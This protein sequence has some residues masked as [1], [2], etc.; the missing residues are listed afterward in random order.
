MDT[1]IK[2]QNMFSFSLLP[3]IIIGSLVA[4]YVIYLILRVVLKKVKINKAN[5]PVEVKPVNIPK[6]KEKYI[7]K[8]ETLRNDFDMGK[9]D[10]RGAYQSMSVIIRDFIYAVTGKE[11]QNYT[12]EDVKAANMPALEVLM[13][14]YYTPEFAPLSAGDVIASIDKTKR[15]I[16][17]WN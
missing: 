12:L 7:R 5:K 15:A 11:V 10:I 16:E 8:L 17:T 1:K 9:I 14:E 3:I 4:L 2:L 13:E 6:N